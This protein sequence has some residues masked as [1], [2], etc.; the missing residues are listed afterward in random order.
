M[1]A[2]AAPALHQITGLAVQTLVS[3]LLLLGMVLHN[4]S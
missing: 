1:L 4:P 3:Q 2:V